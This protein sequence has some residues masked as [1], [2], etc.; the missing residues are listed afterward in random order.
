[1]ER[2]ESS[3]EK[4]EPEYTVLAEASV[5]KESLIRSLLPLCH[6]GTTASVAV[7]M[8]RDGAY[9]GISFNRGVPQTGCDY[10]TTLYA[11]NPI[12][13]DDGEIDDANVKFHVTEWHTFLISCTPQ[14]IKALQALQPDDENKFG[15]VLTRIDTAT[16]GQV[17]SHFIVTG[18]HGANVGSRITHPGSLS[19]S[20][21]ISASNL[22]DLRHYV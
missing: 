11:S 2:E 15:L 12:A 6:I 3:K 10:P 8:N 1:M 21:T 22:V 7:L 13:N 4:L 16:P 17:E 5:D 14:F 9:E 20:A 19:E 18:L